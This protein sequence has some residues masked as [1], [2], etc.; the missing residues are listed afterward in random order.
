MPKS[1][2]L[3]SFAKKKPKLADSRTPSPDPLRSHSP[4]SSTDNSQTQSIASQPSRH[5]SEVSSTDSILSEVVDD[6]PTFESERGLLKWLDGGKK[7]LQKILGSLKPSAVSKPRGPYYKTQV[8]AAPSERTARL[9]RAQDRKAAAEHGSGLMS[10]FAPKQPRG[11]EAEGAAVIDVD[12]PITPM[13]MSVDTDRHSQIPGAATEMHGDTDMHRLEVQDDDIVDLSRSESPTQSELSRLD[14]DG[15][16]DLEDI[17]ASLQLDDPIHNPSGTVP[18]SSAS[19]PASV[20]RPAVRFGPISFNRADDTFVPVRSTVPGAPPLP[21]VIDEAIKNL[22]FI[23]N[24]LR[25]PNT[26]GYKHANLNLVLRAR[27]ELMLS[28]LRLYAAEGYTDWVKT[29]DIVAKSAGKGAWMS[30]RIREWVIAFAKD[31]SN[32]PTA[33]YGKFNASL[34][35]DEDLAQEIHLHL[36]TLGPSRKKTKQQIEEEKWEEWEEEPERTFIGTADGKVDI[37][38]HATLM[39][40]RLDATRPDE[41]H[42]LAY[43]NAAIHTARAVDALSARHMPVKTPGK[44]KKNRRAEELSCQ[45]ENCGRGSTGANARCNILRWDSPITLFPGWACKGGD[46]QGN[47]HLDS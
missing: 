6:V 9:K 13:E 34:L 8:G 11:N 5:A 26:S 1:L 24:P 3:G 25:G 40:D 43:D 21:A 7:H 10:W 31:E 41:T 33:E 19:I 17:F 16:G 22:R 35:E 14:E 28:F 37:L 15:L 39:M 42:V 46:F 36:Q 30:R 4:T 32:L 47:A 12:A 20:P 38:K 45:K 23:L 2:N 44:E 27:L 29:A 18:T